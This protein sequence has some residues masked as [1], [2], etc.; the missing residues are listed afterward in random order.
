MGTTRGEL[1]KKTGC[2]AETIRYYEKIGVM[3]NPVRTA[4]GYRQY[5]Q[6][7]EQRLRFIIRGRELGFAVEDLKSL[8]DLVDRNAVSCSEVSA[9]AQVHLESVRQKIDDLKQ[10]EAVLA[11]TVRSC[12]GKDGPECPLIDALYVQSKYS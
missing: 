3:P 1:A 12:S 4:A 6:A 8:L 10:I 2:N 5:N 7:Q 11:R 9:L